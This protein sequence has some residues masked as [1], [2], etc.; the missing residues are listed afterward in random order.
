[1]TEPHDAEGFIPLTALSFNILLALADA[2]RHGYAIIKEIEHRTEGGMSP[3]TGT[4]Y[5]ALQRFQDDGLIVET[6]D[7][8]SQGRGRRK[9]R[10]YELT[11]LGRRVTALEAERIAMQLGVALEKRLLDASALEPR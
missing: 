8:G 2:P 4:V 7:A 6:T 11:P 1:M 3:G 10:V 9:R 5:L